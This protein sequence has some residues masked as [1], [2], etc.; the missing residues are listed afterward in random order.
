MSTIEIPDALAEKLAERAVADG[1]TP[2]ELAASILQERIDERGEAID[3]LEAFIG[4]AN[5]GDPDW[6]S[7]DTAILR[8]EAAQRRSI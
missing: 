5:S 4:S 6:A 7:T 1:T 8:K 2:D 3:R